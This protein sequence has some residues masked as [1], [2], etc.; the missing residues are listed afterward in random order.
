MEHME[1]SE[2]DTLWSMLLMYFFHGIL[3]SGIYIV[4]FFLWSLMLVALL[5][6]G[7]LIGMLLGFVVLFLV[8]GLINTFLMGFL[9]RE[10]RDYE[11]RTLFKHGFALFFVLWI[12]SVP[13]FLLTYFIPG[14]LTNLIAFVI[15]CF[16]FG[17][18]AKIVGERIEE[19]SYVDV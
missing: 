3:F 8:I 19:S 15:N 7:L 9:W 13:T 2:H 18:L 10:E 1:D 17:F 14:F 4:M 5:V 6:V 11:W 16:L 12:A